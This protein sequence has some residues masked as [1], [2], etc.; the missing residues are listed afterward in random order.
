MS[1]TRAHRLGSMRQNPSRCHGSAE[2]SS[3]RRRR[4]RHRAAGDAGTV[5]P[6]LKGKVRFTRSNDRWRNYCL[7]RVVTQVIVVRLQGAL[8][9]RRECR[10]WPTAGL[11][12]PERSNA[13]Q[14]R[15]DSSG[16]DAARYDG[17]ISSSRSV[18]GDS[19]GG[20]HAPS[21]L[22]L[23]RTHCTKSLRKTGS[24]RSCAAATLSDGGLPFAP[25]R[26]VPAGAVGRLAPVRTRG[27]RKRATR[28]DSTSQRGAGRE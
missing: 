9:P 23:S 17:G 18:S 1:T 16:D 8:G 15:R 20:K 4:Q 12:D 14:R 27:Q 7:W 19:L 22:T 24:A 13:R 5:R 28:R 26:P 21:A 25:P 3:L 10:G 6:N 2:T 11:G